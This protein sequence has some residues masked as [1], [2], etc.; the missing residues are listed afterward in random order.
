MRS[1]VGGMTVTGGQ[2]NLEMPLVSGFN[3]AS[4][5]GGDEVAVCM[6]CDAVPYSVAL[7]PNRISCQNRTKRQLYSNKKGP[8]FLK[9]RRTRRTSALEIVGLQG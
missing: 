1:W 5:G 3:P 6:C 8:N 7:P 9:L 4:H 2:R